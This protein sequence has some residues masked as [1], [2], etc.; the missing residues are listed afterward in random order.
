MGSRLIFTIRHFYVHIVLRV[1]SLL[2][3][4]VLERC[5]VNLCV[6]SG[7]VVGWFVSNVILVT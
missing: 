1:S 2:I 3:M 6:L 4:K 5:L 7:L